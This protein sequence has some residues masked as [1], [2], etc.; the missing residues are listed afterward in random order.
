VRVPKRRVFDGLRDLSDDFLEDIVARRK[1]DAPL[2]LDLERRQRSAGVVRI[3]DDVI[4][5]EPFVRTLKRGA[6]DPR[7]WE[8]AGSARAS[9]ESR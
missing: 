3:D 2:H 1:L 6:I 5:R 7:A 4:Q 8:S 9:I